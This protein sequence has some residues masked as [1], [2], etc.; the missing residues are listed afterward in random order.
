M[1]TLVAWYHTSI[2]YAWNRPRSDETFTCLVPTA[3]STS[4]PAKH[5]SQMQINS[6][7]RMSKT[8]CLCI[9]DGDD[10][11]MT[12]KTSDTCHRPCDLA[13]RPAEWHWI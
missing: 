13:G 5:H 6:H 12:A 8:L 9:C 4:T 1:T 10:S 2:R 3:P 11:S 7:A